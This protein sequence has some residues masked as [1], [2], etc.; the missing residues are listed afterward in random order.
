MSGRAS[1]QVPR[2]NSEPTTPPTIFASSLFADVSEFCN[3]ALSFLE[4]GPNPDM[5]GRAAG[6]FIE[7]DASQ[8]GN[9]V[10]DSDFLESHIPLQLLLVSQM[11]LSL[12]R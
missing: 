3:I 11:T 2:L 8:T 4:S 7:F 1:A 10:F 6:N 12:E 5:I 9:S